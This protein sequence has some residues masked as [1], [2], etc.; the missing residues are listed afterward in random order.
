VPGCS[1][2]PAAAVRRPR[3]AR[4]RGAE[5]C[6]EQDLAQLTTARHGHAPLDG[7]GWWNRSALAARHRDA[8]SNTCA[9]DL[10]EHSGTDVQL[11]A[12]DTQRKRCERAHSG[13]ARTFSI[14]SAMTEVTRFS[15]SSLFMAA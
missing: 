15:S 11:H 8:E 10:H 5:R 6:P 13:V 14:L 7:N 9:S 4:K 12:A 2:R 3:L 1:Y